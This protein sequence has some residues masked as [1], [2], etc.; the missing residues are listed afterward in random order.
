M[1]VV[2]SLHRRKK[3]AIEDVTLS[4]MYHVHVESF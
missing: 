3:V 1:Q 4:C 2:S